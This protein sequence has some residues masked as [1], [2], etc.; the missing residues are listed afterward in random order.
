MGGIVLALGL[1]DTNGNLRLSKHI[2][3]LGNNT[4][5]SVWIMES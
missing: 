2:D 4:F 3:I 1:G 5:T